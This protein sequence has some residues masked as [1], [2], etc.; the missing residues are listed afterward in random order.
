MTTQANNNAAD[1]G[2]RTGLV[3]LERAQLEAARQP[4]FGFLRPWTKPSG[5]KAPETA[6]EI[7]AAAL[8]G[9]PMTGYRQQH[10]FNGDV[11]SQPEHRFALDGKVDLMD[12]ERAQQEQARG[13]GVGALNPWAKP[14]LKPPGM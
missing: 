6:A 11:G 3:D 5:S 12:L 13:P 10:A 14:T 7:T 1:S 2:D 9:D 8:D 4:G